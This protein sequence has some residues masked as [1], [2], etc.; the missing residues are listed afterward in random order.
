MVLMLKI[1]KKKFFLSFFAVV[2]FLATTSVCYN[3]YFSATNNFVVSSAGKTVGNPDIGG[4][5]HLVDHTSGICT[6]DDFYGDFLL[7]YFGYIF[8]PDICPTALHNISRALDSL[9]K[10]KSS[11]IKPIF[12]TIDP[13]RDDITS[14]N[15]YRKSFHKSY[16][17]LTGSVESI[18][19]IAKKYKVYYN[20][21]STDGVSTDY[22]V[23][24]SSIIYLI[25][26]SGKF[27]AHF[28]HETSSLEIAKYINNLMDN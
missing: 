13:E 27:I 5:F 15:A 21:I 2:S 6:D 25:D 12:I 28:N 26:R 14:I 16:A 23:D 3:Y 9:E 19:F 1:T 20:L 17:M 7:V 24:H 4:P 10:G 22:F 11:R 8:C 18:E